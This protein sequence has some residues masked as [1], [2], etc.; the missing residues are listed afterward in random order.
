[1]QKVIAVAAMRRIANAAL[2][3]AVK[4][5][6]GREEEQNDCRHEHDNTMDN[7]KSDEAAKVRRQPRRKTKHI[8]AEALIAHYLV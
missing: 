5:H 8:L 2:T 3:A 4:E 1:M 7:S 6:R